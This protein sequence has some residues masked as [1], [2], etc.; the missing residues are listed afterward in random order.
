MRVL[1]ALLTY[2]VSLFLV[3]AAAFII[4]IVAAGP[5]AGL[6][7][8]WMEGL[9]LAAGWLAV[10]ILPVL[11]TRFVWRKGTGMP[12]SPAVEPADKNDHFPSL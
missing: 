3:A 6:L 1:L 4:V 5:H 10:T 12:V 11:A 2:V 8:Q 7:P 9:V